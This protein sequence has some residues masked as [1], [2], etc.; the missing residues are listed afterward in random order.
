M[1]L[2]PYTIYRWTPPELSL[3]EKIWLGEEV[4]KVGR[5][6]FV[7]SLKRRLGTPARGS[8]NRPFTFADVLRDAEKV[9]HASQ[10]RPPMKAVLAALLF[11]GA[12]FWVIAATHHFRSFLGAMLMVGPI[13][14]GSLLWMYSKVDR[15]AQSLIDDYTHAIAN[16]QLRKEE[17]LFSD[18]RLIVRPLRVSPTTVNTGERQSGSYD[19]LEKFRATI[20]DELFSVAGVIRKQVRKT[21]AAGAKHEKDQDAHAGLATPS[22]QMPHELPQTSKAAETISY[23]NTPSKM[24][25]THMWDVLSLILIIVIGVAVILPF[26]HAPGPSKPVPGSSA[27]TPR[28]SQA[29][30]SSDHG[31]R[32]VACDG[33]WFD[34]RLSVSTYQDFLQNCMKNAR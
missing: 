3:P 23:S 13:S 11:V 7:T 25:H 10:S 31:P 17:A 1:F 34:L 12:S 4:A 16:G 24:D 20:H 14:V 22:L 32:R 9:G 21:F 6:A 26:P 5:G 30:G 18:E 19:Y 15:W 8:N 2:V 29:N 28:S 27:P 33:Q